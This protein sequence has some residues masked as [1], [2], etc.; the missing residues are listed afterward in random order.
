MRALI[1]MAASV[2]G[3]LGC[4]TPEQQAM[5]QQAEMD[6]M[7]AEYGPA[8]SQLGYGMNTD[9]WRNCVVQ[10]AAKNGDGRGRVSTS[11]FGS[12]GSWG[13]SGVGIGI[14]VGR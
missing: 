11:I 10:L 1:I 14:G 12:F 4:S 13:G 8:C 3:L 7:I 6:R 9:P 2:I 5:K